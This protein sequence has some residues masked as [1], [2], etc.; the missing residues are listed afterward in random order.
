MF[1]TTRLEVRRIDSA[2]YDA[3]FAVYGDPEGARWVGDGQ[4][5]SPGDCSRWVDVTL[6]N[7]ES[8][9]YGMS[10]VTLREGGEIVGFVGLVHPGGQE[11]PELKYA[12]GRAHWGQGYAT[13]VAAAMLA[14]GERE[15]GMTRVIATTDPGN[16]A[17]H[18]VLEKV[19]MVDIGTHVDEDGDEVKTYEWREGQ[20]PS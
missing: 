9:G 15:F 10:A 17:S 3:M 16:L 20:S 19:G 5:I 14:Y 11:V 12:Y 8:R 1:T 2:D 7:Y 4:P 18:R 6:A 13:E